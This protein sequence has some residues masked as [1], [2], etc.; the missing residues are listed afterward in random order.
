MA[1]SCYL[2][3]DEYRGPQATGEW[4]GILVLNEVLDGD[5]DI[6]EVSL[7]YLCIRYEGMSLDRYV[8]KHSGKRWA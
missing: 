6:C 4:R 2:T 3:A 7:S 8:K 5:F 1:G